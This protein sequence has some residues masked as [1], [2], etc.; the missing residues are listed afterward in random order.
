MRRAN[1]YIGVIMLALAA[2]IISEALTMD[3]TDD[4]IPGPGFAPFWTGAFIV[5]ISLILLYKNGVLRQ[6]ESDKGPGFDNE[7]YRIMGTVIGGCSGS[8]LLVYIVGMLP[9][10]GIM[11]GFLSWMM[12]TK[13]KTTVIALTL[14]TPV[15]FWLIFAM[16][17]EV[18]F[19]GGLLLGL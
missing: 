1:M 18:N 15:M 6:P 4:G 7:A 10:I 14:L 8:M 19:P 12:G 13:N 17:L 5:V 16:A 11:T 2:Y 3:Y 9:A